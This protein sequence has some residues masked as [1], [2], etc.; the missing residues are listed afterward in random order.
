[1]SNNQHVPPNG[2]IF[3]HYKD[4]A[5]YRKLFEAY[6]GYKEES[7]SSLLMSV[8]VATN[9]DPEPYRVIKLDVTNSRIWAPLPYKSVIYISQTTLEVYARE[10]DEFYGDVKTTKSVAGGWAGYPDDEMIVKRFQPVG[11]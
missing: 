11:A 8:R 3:R 4:G 5:L 2:T 1:M 10:Y 7:I 6:P 9:D